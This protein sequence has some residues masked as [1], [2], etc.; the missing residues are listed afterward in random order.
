MEGAHRKPRCHS[1][2]ISDKTLDTWL[3][4]SLQVDLGKEELRP[5]IYMMSGIL[6]WMCPET[7]L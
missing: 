2:H 3:N 5:K 7:S 4:L 1:L 6:I